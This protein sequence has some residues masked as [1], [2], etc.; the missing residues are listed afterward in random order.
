MRARGNQF[1][2]PSA[3]ASTKFARKSAVFLG[4]SMTVGWRIFQSP[5]NAAQWLAMPMACT[6][7]LHSKG[8]KAPR[9]VIAATTVDGDQGSLLPL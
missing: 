7:V 9:Q 3:F 4:F 1:A 6:A 5:I 8:K 2:H